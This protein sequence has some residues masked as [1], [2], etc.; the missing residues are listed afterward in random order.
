MYQK[1]KKKKLSGYRNLLNKRKREKEREKNASRHTQFFTKLVMKN[2][3]E[4]V[5]DCSKDIVTMVSGTCL[6]YTSRCV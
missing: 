3:S 6:L 2:D 5:P 4:P 1:K